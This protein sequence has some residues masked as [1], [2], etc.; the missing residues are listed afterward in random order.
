MERAPAPKEGAAIT[1][2]FSRKCYPKAAFELLFP[3]SGTSTRMGRVG[4]AKETITK[5]IDDIDGGVAHET[6]RFAL[7]GYLYEIDLSSKNAKKLRGE[8]AAYVAGGSRVS[9]RAVAPGPR[10]AGGRGRGPAVADRDQNRAIRDWALSK[11]F[12]VAPRGRIKQ[13]IVEEYHRTAGR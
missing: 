5:L 3:H 1:G 7:D 4:V 2:C 13:E 6:V 11:G 9:N 8:L 12:D 10:S